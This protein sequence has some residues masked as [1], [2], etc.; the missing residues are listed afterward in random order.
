[1]TIVTLN[2]S[3][4]C[5]LLYWTLW[6]CCIHICL[7]NNKLLFYVFLGNIRINWKR[8]GRIFASVAIPYLF[9]K[10]NCLYWPFIYCFCYLLFMQWNGKFETGV[11]I[12]SDS[13]SNN[14]LHFA[15]CSMALWPGKCGYI[16]SPRGII[17]YRFL[18]S[19]FA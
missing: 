7:V 13:R 10:K 8:T 3:V 9:G 19:Y 11:H 18:D 12:F 5:E 2:N 15:V 17:R 16:P 1:M 6:G 4:A 14:I